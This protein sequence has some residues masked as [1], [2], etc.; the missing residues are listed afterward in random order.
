VLVVDD[1]PTNRRVLDGELKR[2]GLDPE[3]VGS[4]AEALDLLAGDQTFALAILDL[5]MPDVD[6]M[7]LARRIRELP[8]G[9]GLPLIL[10]SSSLVR[11]EDDPERLF[12][13]RLLKPVRHSRLF[14]AIMQA[15][16]GALAAG[17]RNGER[18]DS[19]GEVTP[20][21]I[22]VADDNEINRKLAALVLRRFGYQPDLVI[23]G[24]E[25]VDRVVS[26][27]T[28]GQPYDLVLMDVHMPEMDGLEAT[29]MI[30]QLQSQKPDK[31]WPTI[32]AVT[33]DAMPDDRGIALDAGM[34]E[35]LTK[36]LDFEE[37]RVVLERVADAVRT[38]EPESRRVSAPVPPE[39]DTALMPAAAVPPPSTVIDWSRLDELRSY[40]TPDGALVR[41]A[42]EAFSSQAPAALLQ[43]SGSAATRDGP[44]LR[45]AAH[46]LKGAAMNIGA[47][48]VADH[49]QTLELAGKSMQ[50][51]GVEDSIASLST[52]LV[53]TLV[54]LRQDPTKQPH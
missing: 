35:Y 28:A 46:G 16:G 10:L 3:A 36:P 19:L 44:A 23:N 31:P 24:Q 18:D 50:F 33:A 52:A 17:D 11:S 20:L 43:L 49:A 42:I 6:G 48:A 54:E 15:L 39:D 40:D 25:A 29:R 45:K 7:T 38:R 4:A 41:G 47:S 12:L 51:D 14:D 21:R 1:N 5:H 9:S 2:W 22:L 8:H 27:S 13:A 34:D 26:Q 32:V 37:V 53:Q 30:R